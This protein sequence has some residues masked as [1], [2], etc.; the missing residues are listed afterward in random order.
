MPYIH[1]NPK[2]LQAYRRSRQTQIKPPS[3][4]RNNV[5]LFKAY[6]APNTAYR[7]FHTRIFSQ[8]TISRRNME[9]HLLLTDINVHGTPEFLAIDQGPAY[10]SAEM[11]SALSEAVIALE[12]KTIE[13]PGTICWCRFTTPRCARLTK[14]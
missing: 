14:R 13:N 7:P 9:I 10:I 2:T 3:S 5:H 6:D 8:D 1:Q 11:M 4:S 12:E